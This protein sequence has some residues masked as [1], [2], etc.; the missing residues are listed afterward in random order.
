VATIIRRVFG[1]TTGFIGSQVSY[2]LT[3]ES[4]TIKLTLTT[5]SQLLLSLFRAQ[6][7]LQTQLALTGH[8]L[9]S[10][11]LRLALCNSLDRTAPGNWLLQLSYIAWPAHCWVTWCLPRPPF[12]LCHPRNTSC[13]VYRA[14]A[15]CAS[16]ILF[17]SR[18]AYCL[19]HTLLLCGCLQ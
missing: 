10:G 6:D 1:L 11:L 7:L 16:A 17:T 18:P 19:H 5:E 15:A 2:T 14:A 9:T 8:Q 13:G 12:C 3:T 4:L